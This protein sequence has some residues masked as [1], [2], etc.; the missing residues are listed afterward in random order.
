MK[1]YNAYRPLILNKNPYPN[2]NNNNINDNNINYN[3]NNMF[4]NEINKVINKYPDYKNN[5]LLNN[6]EKNK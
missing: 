2:Q 4:S 1:N 5:F 6:I 3:N